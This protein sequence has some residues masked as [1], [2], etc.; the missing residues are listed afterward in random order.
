MDMTNKQTNKANEEI[1]L[2]PPM[3][4]I[5]PPNGLIRTISQQSNTHIIFIDDDIGEPPMYRDV[6]HCLATCG[7]NDMVNILI[8]SS[9]GRT[10]SVWQIIEAMKG[11]QGEVVATVIGAAYSAASMLACMAPECYIADSAEFMLHTAHYGSIGTVPNVKGQTDFA[12][13]QINKLLDICYTGFLTT[14]ELADLKSG[15][16]F[17]FNAEQSRD[18]MQRRYEYL[19]KEYKKRSKPPVRRSKQPSP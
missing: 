11:C 10:D 6:I 2:M 7:D 18:R 1:I 17:W 12:T 9:G 5:G 4:P 13:N 15:K 8:N 3:M 16:E 19:E 14:K